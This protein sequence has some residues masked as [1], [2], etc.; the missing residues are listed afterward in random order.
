MLSGGSN[1]S[2]SVTCAATTV[3][4][5]SSPNVKS[6]FG[7]RVNV[8]LGL[9]LVVNV[10]EPEVV[11]EIV[12]EDAVAFTASSNVT[13]TLVDGNVVEALVGVVAVTLGGLSVVNDQTKFASMLS[14]GSFASL[15]L[16]CAASTVAVH[17]SLLPKSVFGST[18]HVVG[19][20]LT[21]T[22]CAPVWTQLMVTELLVM[23][24]GSLNVTERFVFVATF[25]EP[26]V[27]VTAVTLGAA[28]TVNVNA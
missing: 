26:F 24:T 28:S 16:T 14:G 9:A 7:L 22:V 8:V 3:T 5:Q 27:G 2:V 6:T 1:A 13:V 11:Q 20:P 15:S 17:S 21:V 23:V 12:N 19:P 18:V 25:V 10:C 4:V